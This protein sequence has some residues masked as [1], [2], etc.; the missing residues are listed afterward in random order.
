MEKRSNLACR[1]ITALQQQTAQWKCIN[2]SYILPDTVLE[3][4]GLTAWRVSDCYHSYFTYETIKDQDQNPDLSDHKICVLY[5]NSHRTLPVSPSDPRSALGSKCSRLCPHF[6]TLAL[7][8]GTGAIWIR[9]MKPT[10][11]EK[12]V[13]TAFAC[14]HFNCCRH[15]LCTGGS[16]ECP[17]AWP[18]Q[19]K[20]WAK[21]TC[22][23]CMQVLWVLG[24]EKQALPAQRTWEPGARWHGPKVTYKSVLKF[25]VQFSR[26]ETG[27]ESQNE[28]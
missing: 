7:L 4:R 13:S 2:K 15:P 19:E 17:L 10:G 23:K 21:V 25:R 22:N 24:K 6:Q 14:N 9:L 8:E 1:V 18:Q 28:D 3:A 5:A 27:S 26:N 12:S 20:A 11:I 16:Q